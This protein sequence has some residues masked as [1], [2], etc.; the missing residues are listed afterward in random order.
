MKQLIIKLGEVVS[1]VC[2]I[3]FIMFVNAQD[4]VSERSAPEVG[5]SVISVMNLEGTV[6]QNEKGL[7]KQFGIEAEAPD[8]FIYYKS[9]DV[10]DVR[11]LLIVKVTDSSLGQQMFSKVEKVLT[12]KKNLFE[13]YAPQQSA[14]LE[15]A[16]LVYENSF[17][18]F[19]VGEDARAAY[20]AF[21]DSL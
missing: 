18:F 19:A 2:L 1:I 5:E 21:S 8:S 16:V 15:N 7:R 3:A 4:K 13:A 9:E 6:Q 20:S 11:E 10:M 12:D 14:L 17:I